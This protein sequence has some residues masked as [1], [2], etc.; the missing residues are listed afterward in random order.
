MGQRDY[1]LRQIEQLGSAYGALIRSAEERKGLQYRAVGE[2]ADQTLRQHFGL[3]MATAKERSA[4]ELIGLVR[5]GSSVYAGDGTVGDRLT[6]LAAILRDL[7]DSDAAAGDIEESAIGRMKALQI[8]LTVLI[9]EDTASEYAAG[10][11]QPLLDVLASYE[12]PSTMQNLLW[13]YA[14]QAGDFARAEDWLFALLDEDPGALEQGIAFYERLTHFTD[15]E[16]VQG[17]LPRAEVAASLA[18]LRTRRVSQG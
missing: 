7:A 15:D 18:E 10:A 8:F 2:T 3:S 4:E 6:L 1:I 5:M 17:N 9:E 13:R 12:F 16:L 11:V 14:E